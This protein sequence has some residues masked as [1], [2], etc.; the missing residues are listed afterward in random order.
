MRR[1]ILHI[2]KLINF[3]YKLL[4]AAWLNNFYTYLSKRKLQT[5]DGEENFSSSQN[6]VL[7]KQP[8]HVH[9]IWRS[10]FFKLNSKFPLKRQWQYCA[11]HVSSMI[12]SARP[13]VPPVAITISLICFHLQEFEK[14]GQTVNRCEIVTTTFRDSGSAP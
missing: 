1:A 13:T 10:N 2:N 7:W 9:W 11:R 4:K 6:E 5:G 8:E 3:F 12:F 14:W